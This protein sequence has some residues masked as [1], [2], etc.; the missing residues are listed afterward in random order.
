MDQFEAAVQENQERFLTE[1]QEFCRKPSI[2]T[3]GIGI[4]ETAEFV[5]Q[6][7][8]QAGFETRIIPVEG[9]SPV[10][11]G[12]IGAGDKTLMIYNHYD[13]QPPEPLELWESGPF[14]AEI[15][16]GRIFARGVSD[17]K[18]PL[19]AR[20]Q[21]IE[22]YQAAFGDLPLKIKCVIE[23][24]EE[25]GSPN[26]GRFVAENR[27]LL[28]GAEACLWEGGRRDATGRPVI[29]LGMK[30]ICYLELSVTG[31]NSDLHSS[32]GPLVG[33]PAW[34]LNWALSS[35]KDQNERITV[36]GFMDHVV[37]PTEQEWALLREI[38]FEEEQIKE[39][40]GITS[41][42]KNVSGVDAVKQ[43]LFDPTCTIC[44]FATGYTGAGMKTVLPNKATAKVDF[45]LVPNLTPDLVYRLVREH[46]DRRGFT[47]VEVTLLAQLWP[48]RS[49][50]DHPWVQRSM[51]VAAEFYGKTPVVYPSSAGGGPM[52]QV[53][54]ALGV[55]GISGGGVGHPSSNIHAPNENIFVEDYVKALNFTGH[56]IRAL[57]E[58]Q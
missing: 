51:E 7:L 44:G 21:A 42:V 57:A 35:F 40:F 58:I 37:E 34:R 5:A 14:D 53:C 24:E 30:G 39:N 12:E 32:W 15:R 13:V 20:I 46:L 28:E 6:R 22:A 29:S 38:P 43:Y 1:L 11:F 48:H 52:Y 8:R 3:Q 16:E 25:I 17:N 33:N 49:P 19:M 2:V 56:L 41:F 54:G 45:R 23:G 55:P 36:D 9:G 4:E 10:V 27:E 31:A 26:L 18:G 50:V 47:D